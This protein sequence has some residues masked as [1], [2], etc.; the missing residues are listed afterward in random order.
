MNTPKSVT[1]VTLPCTRVPTG[2]AP[3]HARPRILGELLDA[4]RDALVLDVDA[5]HHRLDLVALLEELRR[6][7]DLL[8]PVQIGDVHQAVDPLFD[9]DEDAEVGEV[10]DRSL[11]VAADRVVEA[12]HLPRVGLGLLEPNE[13]LRLRC[14]HRAPLTSTSWATS[15]IFDGCVTRL[16]H[17]ISETCTRPS[18]PASSSTKAP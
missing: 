5:E 3:A 16:V 10:L 1:L 17:D 11:D 7:A 14:R 4:Q 8:G 9:A 18:M 15:R 2:K 6:M 13:M 12:H